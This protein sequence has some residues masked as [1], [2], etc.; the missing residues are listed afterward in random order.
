VSAPGLDAS[1]A[2]IAWTPGTDQVKVGPLLNGGP[3]WTCPYSHTAGAAYVWMRSASFAERQAQLF[4]EAIHLIV[5][6]RC[7]PM[8]VHRALSVLP[9][10][11]AGLAE[12]MP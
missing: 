8:A 3:D 7:E 9:E 1:N 11:R 2:I 6:D 4:I 5:R 12:D 10:Y